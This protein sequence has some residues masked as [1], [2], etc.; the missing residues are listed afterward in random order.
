MPVLGEIEAGIFVDAGTS[1]HGFKLAP[2]WGAHV[3]DLVL[4]QRPRPELAQFHPDRFRTNNLLHG[5][6]GTARILG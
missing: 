6:Y 4:G 3:A 1:G 5:G 2:S